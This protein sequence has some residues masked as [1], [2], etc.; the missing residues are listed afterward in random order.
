MKNHD[1]ASKLTTKLREHC[2]AQPHI[3]AV[4]LFG[5]YAKGTATQ[6]SDVDVALLLDR[7]VD[8]RQNVTYRLEQT[9]ALEEALTANRGHVDVVILNQAPL[10]LRHQVFKYGQLIYEADHRRRVNFEVQS[11]QAYLDAYNQRL[12]EHILEGTLAHRYRGDQDPLGDARRT[13]E[14]FK[15]AARRNV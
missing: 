7:D 4:Y 6:A 13:F 14:R 10:V 3:L 15:R 5:S 2:R 8:L 9:T 1:V 11:M 12:T